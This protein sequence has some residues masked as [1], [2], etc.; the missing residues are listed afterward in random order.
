MRRLLLLACFF[1][2]AFALAHGGPKHTLDGEVTSVKIR[3]GMYM[4]VSPMGGNVVLAAGEDGAFIVDDQLE[5][6]SS[7]IDA[8]IKTVGGKP[9]QF[10]LNT[11]YHFD[12]TGGNEHF[13]DSG[14]IIMAHDKVRE[15]LSSRQFISYF[16]R[17]MLP[18][19]KEG[20]P[21]VTFSDGMTLHYNGDAVHILHLPAAHTDGDA[22]AHFQQ[23][24]VIAAGDLVFNGLYPFIDA[25]H[26]GSVKGV[27]AGLDTMLGLADADT[28]IVPGHGPLMNKQELKEYRA[29]LA[30]VSGRVE[31]GIRKGKS[32]QQVIASKPSA[33]F[34]AEQAEGIVS[35]DA[36]V[37]LLYNDLKR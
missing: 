14:A 26:G 35:P 1:F 37:E 4:L 20:L 27:I 5:P 36:F 6:R 10:I 25:E 2:P 17:E 11:H 34:D 22:I 30:T 31:E 8:A 13:G 21:V 23:S 15:R 16:K 28:L 3:D 24:N 9:V 18:T 33:E 32:L 7:I 29:M 12:H 19:A